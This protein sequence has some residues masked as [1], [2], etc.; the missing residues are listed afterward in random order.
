MAARVPNICVTM[1]RMC[2]PIIVRTIKWNNDLVNLD[3]RVGRVHCLLCMR[4]M[5]TGNLSVTA[6]NPWPD[7]AS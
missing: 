5:N 7:L 1:E 6:S 3:S 4:P 2:H